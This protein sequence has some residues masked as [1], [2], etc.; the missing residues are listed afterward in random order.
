CRALIGLIAIAAIVVAVWGHLAILAAAS[1]PAV[2]RDDATRMAT[3]RLLPTLG[4]LLIVLAV[5]ALLF[6]PMGII[7]AGS[8]VDMQAMAGGTNVNLPPQTAAI[9]ALYTLV[10]LVIAIGVGARLA[11]LYPVLLLERTGV[12]A[13]ARS[14]RLTRGLTWRIIGV[15]VLY[16]IV[17]LVAGGAAQLVAGTIAALILGAGATATFIAA[18]AGALVSTALSV[19]AIVFTA[20][21]YLA[22]R[23]ATALP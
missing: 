22:A 11:L 20:Q 23:E 18:V 21:L 1:D 4:V 19:V 16:A 12:G 7:L 6:V 15:L 9:I 5:V 3:R 13:F 10:F 2:L 17:V 14:F 8:G